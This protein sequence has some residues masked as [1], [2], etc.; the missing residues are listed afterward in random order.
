MAKLNVVAEQGSQNIVSIVT[1]R[2][3]LERVFAAHTDQE[4]FARWW[5]G[6]GAMTVH[7]FIPETGGRWH[8]TTVSEHGEDSFFGTFHEVEQDTRIIQTFEWLGASERGHVALERADFDRLGDR[9]T[10]ITNT[11]TYQSADD[12]Q[13]MVE[14]GMESGF[15]HSVYALGS[16]LGDDARE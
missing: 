15:R 13:A 7:S 4:L 11:S 12:A 16:L 3:P 10:R 1:I 14:S 2:A 9:M 5:G 8:I 6:G